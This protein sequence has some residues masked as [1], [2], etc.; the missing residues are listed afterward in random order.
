MLGTFL[1]PTHLDRVLCFFPTG[2][3]GFICEFLGKDFKTSG[4]DWEV[5]DGDLG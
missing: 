3:S 1:T 5:K 2:V 4:S